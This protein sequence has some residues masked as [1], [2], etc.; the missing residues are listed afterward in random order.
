MRVRFPRPHAKQREILKSKARYKLVRA[1]RRF[2]KTTL[3]QNW[4]A[5][6]LID[7]LPCALVSMSFKDMMQVWRDFE[8]LLHPIIKT[9]NKSDFRMEL[10][11]GGI[12][13]FYSGNAIDS[14]RGKKYARVGID[15]AAQIPHLMDGLVNAVL[16][17]LIDY[18]GEL[19]I[20]STPLGSNDFRKL[21]E[22]NINKP[23]WAM[24]HYTSY[25]NPYLPD[26]AIDDLIE[27]MTAKAVQQ[28]IM[29]E[30][31]DN[32]DAA[33]FKQEFIKRWNDGELD[34][35]RIVVGVDPAV[36]SNATSDE[37]GIIVA[38]LCENDYFVLADGSG[39][40]TPK[41]WAEKVNNLYK[42]W[43][44]DMVIGEVN[45]GGDLVEA[46]L[47]NTNREISYRAV[48]ASR[49]KAIRA[50]PIAALYENGRVYHN[51]SFRILETQMITWSPADDDSPDRIDALVWALTELS[52]NKKVSLSF[53]SKSRTWRD[54][55]KD[56]E[57]GKQ[58][59]TY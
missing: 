43:D 19:L 54:Y 5:Q 4:Y 56:N 23:D 6:P 2:G 45:N 33:L 50:E 47:R 13:D 22:D 26:G 3:Y 38:G 49:G 31:L 25:D 37:T 48:R 42:T 16:P 41:A 11:T 57:D 35:S 53:G 29:A 12:L 8:N 9:K 34:Y 51:D 36:T 1:G 52:S 24:F 59:P 10:V 39:I 20:T 21:E 17:T 55:E 30:F 7:G 28:E 32:S 18:S 27:Q 44:A 15:E 58:R 14:T 46:N 40:Y